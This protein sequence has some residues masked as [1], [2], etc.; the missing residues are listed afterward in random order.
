MVNNKRVAVISDIHA[1]LA[2]LKV[3][4]ADIKAHQIKRVWCLG[5]IVGYGPQPNECIEE[6]RKLPL[7]SV[8]GNHDLGI[9][10]RLDL[11][12]FNQPG[13]IAIEWQRQRLSVNSVNFLKSLAPKEHPVPEVI[14]VHASLRDPAWEY[15]YSAK[16]AADN[17]ERL[18]AKICFFGHTHLPIIYWKENGSELKTIILPVNEEYAL[19]GNS[20]W[21][22]NPGSVGQ[23]RDNNPKAGYIIFDLKK[24]T[25]ENRRLDY[26]IPETRELIREFG[27]PSY[28][29][30]RL[31]VG[32]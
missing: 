21:L 26:P 20:R 29:G 12:C 16:L 13:Q 18:A 4:I 17:I 23:P 11:T 25:L 6:L 2:A 30:E 7:I 5:D 1:N 10:N 3:I 19:T 31:V 22:I 27:L 28:L 15:I 32:K 8:A 24:M 9:I 14:M